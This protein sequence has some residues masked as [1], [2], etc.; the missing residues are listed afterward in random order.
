M[1]IPIKSE[2]LIFHIFVHDWYVC[3]YY[4]EYTTKTT[5][6]RGLQPSTSVQLRWRKNEEAYIVNLE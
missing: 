1:D 6:K 2:N 3:A 5:R 4:C